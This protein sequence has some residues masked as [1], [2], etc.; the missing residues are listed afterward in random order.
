MRYAIPLLAFIG[1]GCIHPSTRI[2]RESGEFVSDYHRI[3]VPSFSDERGQGAVLADTLSKGLQARLDNR[4]VDRTLLDQAL[5]ENKIV[6]AS[7]LDIEVLARLRSR[8]PFDALIFGRMGADWKQAAIVMVDGKT[9]ATVIHGTVVPRGG[10][11]P[12]TGPEEVSSE[13]LRAISRLPKASG[14]G[15]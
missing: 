7:D 14:I 8:V 3:A 9:G 1:L 2:D 6:D 4:P 10:E 5:S 13:T 11:R 15:D 12:F